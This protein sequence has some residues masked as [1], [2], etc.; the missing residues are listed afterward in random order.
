[1]LTNI[2]CYLILIN[3]YIR[4][5]IKIIIFLNYFNNFFYK[6]EIKKKFCCRYYLIKYGL[7][8]ID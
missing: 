7:I 5:N 6:I 4:L 2:D 8:G 1:M 3:K